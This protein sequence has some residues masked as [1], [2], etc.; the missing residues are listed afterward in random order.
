M[1]N[2]FDLKV[3]HLSQKENKDEQSVLQQW[4]PVAIHHTPTL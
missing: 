4:R 1:A 2:P 3:F